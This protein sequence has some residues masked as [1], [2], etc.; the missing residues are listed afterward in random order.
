[1]YC[2]GTYQHV[3]LNF[4]LKFDWLHAIVQR[5]H[6]VFTNFHFYNVSS[7]NLLCEVIYT[8]FECEIK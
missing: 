4:L 5:A 6:I 1:M 3:G 2:R 7:N 8:P